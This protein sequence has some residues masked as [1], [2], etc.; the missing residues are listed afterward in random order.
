MS[1]QEQCYWLSCPAYICQVFAVIISP[2]YSGSLIFSA[3]WCVYSSGCE[4]QF[5]SLLTSSTVIDTSLPAIRLGPALSGPMITMGSC[6]LVVLYMCLRQFQWHRLA[7]ERL[8]GKTHN[9]WDMCSMPVTCYMWSSEKWSDLDR[10]TIACDN[11]TR[12]RLLLRRF[13]IQDGVLMKLAGCMLTQEN[14]CFKFSTLLP[15]ISALS[16]TFFSVSSQTL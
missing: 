11:D 1:Y 15:R 4:S 6:L 3:A 16:L 8:Q 10:L 14:K 12:C 9:R 7:I 5:D 13:H 2:P